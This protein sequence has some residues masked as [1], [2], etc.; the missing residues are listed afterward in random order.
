MNEATSI[1]FPVEHDDT[2]HT[3]EVTLPADK[4]I[5]ELRIDPSIAPGE[6]TL[7]DVELETAEGYLLRRWRFPSGAY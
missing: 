3:Y 1:A 6:F 7:R 4:S 5:R 2:F